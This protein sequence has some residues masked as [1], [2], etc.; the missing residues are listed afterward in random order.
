MA[1]LPC[2]PLP[3]LRRVVDPE[4]RTPMD[5]FMSIKH[6]MAVVAEE[7]SGSAAQLPETSHAGR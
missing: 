2:K 3:K 1:K 4:R 7:H 6:R 5:G